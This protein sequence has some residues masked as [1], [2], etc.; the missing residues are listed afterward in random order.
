MLASSAQASTIA[1]RTTGVAGAP[2]K[3]FFN[4]DG[5]A[6]FCGDTLSVPTQTTSATGSPFQRFDFTNFVHEP[7]C[8][9]AT[10]STMC[11]G[12]N[13][14]M[15]ESY[16]PAFVLSD[17]RVN[18][19]GDLG[20]SPPN[21][22]AYS[23]T[24]PALATFTTVIDQPQTATAACASVTITWTSDR[25]W[26]TRAPEVNGV[27]AVGQTLT[28]TV[29]AW[30]GNPAV[31]RQ[32]RRC[33]L[34]GA[35]CADI[36]GAT[37][38]SYVVTDADVGQTVRVRESATEAALTSTSDSVATNEVFIPVETHDGRLQSGDTSESGSIGLT[39]VPSR[40]GTSTAFPGSMDNNDHFFDTFTLTSLVNESACVWVARQEGCLG[41]LVVYSPTFV[42]TDLARNFTAS[43][44]GTG[45]LSYALAPAA[46]AEAT[47]VES[48]TFHLCG[49][50]SLVI[51]SDA[52]FASA[53]PVLGDSATEGVPVT[54]TNGAW[55]GAPAFAAAWLRCDQDGNSCVPIDGANASS[56][57]P[58]AA[59]VGH[60][61]RSRVTA[62]EGKSLS[63]DSLPSAVI[64]GA[65]PGAPGGPGGPGAGGDTTGPKAQF[66]LK[67]T[68][69]QKV[70][71]SGRIP[72]TATC[73]EACSLSV[74][75]DVTKKLGKRLGGVK[76][77]S[78]KGSAKA[79]RKTTL[80]LKLT[81]KARKALRRQ[82]SV[83]FT[84]KATAT[85]AAGNTSNATKKAKVR[86]KR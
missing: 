40:C 13:A 9:T 57:T 30:S 69:L 28:D 63:A 43:D 32:W 67:R 12:T 59:D 68:T 1:T 52:P 16:S 6:S 36:P 46:S 61:L 41:N 51:G 53:R 64:A 4:R 37:G 76:I 38:S 65:P 83:A 22:T 17:L 14:I 75:A 77:A 35:N 3:N 15:S 62:T 18:W 39:G 50:Y 47:I 19:I 27:P 21:E 42:P 45:A 48:G 10:I 73:D 20:N 33:D 26:A 56:Y 74:R 86:R 7:V 2:H 79:G 49:S 78:G 34:A 71:K 84:L 8:V 60:R 66:A 55:S 80:K 54:T 81:R 31:G 70:V 72:I 24:V 44:D 85:D 58:T 11:A 29:D 23:F 25:P 82:T 5:L